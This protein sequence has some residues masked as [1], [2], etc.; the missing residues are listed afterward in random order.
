MTRRERKETNMPNVLDVPQYPQTNAEIAAGVTPTN[1]GVPPYEPQR[2]GAVGNNSAN[3][4]QAF[5]NMLRAAAA[6]GD[7]TS[8][9]L[10]Q[11]KAAPSKFRID[12]GLTFDP[13]YVMLDGHGNTL[14]FSNV[15]TG[16]SFSGLKLSCSDDNLNR[17]AL[18][19]AVRGLR[20]LAIEVPSRVVGDVKSVGIELVDEVGT[21][22]P[23]D[24][25]KFNFRA[26]TICL[27]NVSVIGGDAALKFGNGAWGSTITNFTCGHDTGNLGGIGV[28]APQFWVDGQECPKFIGGHISNRTQ[29]FHLD[30]GSVKVIG[31]SIDG[32]PIIGYLA[33]A[34]QMSFIGGYS[35]FT[36]GDNSQPKFSVLDHNAVLEIA[37]WEFSVRTDVLAART[38]AFID[39]QGSATNGNGTVILR[40]LK[41][42]GTNTGWYQANG[43]FLVAGE[44]P[45]HASGLIYKDFAWAP[46]AAKSLQWL[47][48]PD[49][50]HANALAAFTLSNAGAFNPARVTGISDGFS[51][52]DAIR[53]QI[54]SGAGSG[55]HSSATFTRKISPGKRVTI[56][57]EALT[58][59]LTGSN[60]VFEVQV[61]HKDAAGN[62]LFNPAAAVIAGSSQ[63]PGFTKWTTW[64]TD[65]GTPQ[66]GAAIGEFTIRARAT[67]TA[68]GNTLVHISP[69]GIGPSSGECD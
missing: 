26:A 1:F 5:D 30:V 23:L 21:P 25:E 62:V 63:A 28:Y 20:N 60:V 2:Y 67:G 22:D 36:E 32:C 37:S 64:G 15:P 47:P 69:L 8:C 16:N 57:G 53:L 43:G 13:Q 35:E 29:A 59:A 66:Q 46:L 52:R 6:E 54:N 11:I 45:V 34:G 55:S 9:T 49:I 19:H 7:G 27:E 48:Y 14:N 3:D 56:C 41:F 24:P 12:S 38:K 17:T 44:G 10:A 51:T 68:N 33:G 4:W 50:N 18:R 61:V 42:Q 39:T 40:N 31:M 58:G 65:G